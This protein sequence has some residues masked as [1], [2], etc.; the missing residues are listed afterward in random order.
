MR[1]HIP[2]SGLCLKL[3][4]WT[5]WTGLERAINFVAF[6]DGTKDSQVSYSDSQNSFQY[7]GIILRRGYFDWPATSFTW[8]RIRNFRNHMHVSRTGRL[9]EFNTY[10]CN[11]IIR[12]SSA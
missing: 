12:Y 10:V 3:A 2:C 11:H 5:Q 9:R 1:M 4:N 8:C 7:F 6:Q